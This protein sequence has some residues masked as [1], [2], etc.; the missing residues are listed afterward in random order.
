MHA[1]A[2]LARV[3]QQGAARGERG[4]AV[5][6]TDVLPSQLAS[7]DTD[8]DL[9]FIERTW[10]AALPHLGGARDQQGDV[11]GQAGAAIGI[12]ENI[13]NDPQYQR[14]LQLVQALG[15]PRSRMKSELNPAPVTTVVTTDR[16]A[17]TLLREY[18]LMPLMRIEEI[19]EILT[20]YLR[21][22][23]TQVDRLLEP[24]I[25]SAA[26]RADR[27]ALEYE[28]RLED[29]RVVNQDIRLLHPLVVTAL[30]RPQ[31]AELYLLAFAAG[32]VK[33][34]R[35]RALL[36]I[37]GQPDYTLDL[38]GF[39]FD[40]RIAGLLRVSAGRPEDAARMAALQA[41]LAQPDAAIEQ[42]WRQFVRGYQQQAQQPAEPVRRLCV[43]GHTMKPDA[44]RCGECGG[45]PAPTPSQPP[46]T[47]WRTPFA[48]DP[49]EVRDLGVIAALAAYRRLAPEEWDDLVMQRPR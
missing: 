23:G 31:L 2:D 35:E 14:L 25:E 10:A 41:L 1:T 28:R 21:N 8:P 26:F 39:D 29:P 34:E 17:I 38:P 36:V 40:A 48:D 30:E 4:L 12:P 3:V 15:T 11:D 16:T 33:V 9:R 19:Q 37:P 20:T 18:T 45:L 49:Q 47:P 5:E 24:T 43:N 27:G 6:I 13:L 46:A 32:L 44:R 42:A 7:N 22:A